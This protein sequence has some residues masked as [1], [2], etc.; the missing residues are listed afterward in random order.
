MADISDWQLF[1]RFIRLAAALTGQ[2]INYSQLGRELGLTPQTAK[3]WIDI[4]QA[5]FQWFEVPA[6]SGN[7]IKKVSNKPK[8]YIGDT[9]LAC[10]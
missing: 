8:G 9:G 6:F 3:R 5:T 10:A 2:E 4:L 7:A 1:G